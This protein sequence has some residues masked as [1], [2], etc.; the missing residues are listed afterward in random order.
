L[1]GFLLGLKLCLVTFFI[2]SCLHTDLE[3]RGSGWIRTAISNDKKEG[4]VDRLGAAGKKQRRSLKL[5]RIST[6]TSKSASSWERKGLRINSSS[7]AVVS[8]DVLEQWAQLANLTGAHIRPSH[9][10]RLIMTLVMKEKV[11]PSCA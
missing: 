2:T 1:F 11:F 9:S 5:L 10:N 3:P 6:A 4:V 7:V 8:P